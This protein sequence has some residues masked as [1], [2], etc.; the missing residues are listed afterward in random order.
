MFCIKVSRWGSPF[1][2]STAIHRRL[3]TDFPLQ[4]RVPASSSSMSSLD[5]CH[6]SV[7]YTA[8]AYRGP[9]E[10]VLD[11]ASRFPDA[12]FLVPQKVYRPSTQSDRPRSVDKFEPEPPIMFLTQHPDGCGINCRDAMNSRSSRLHGRDDS[13]FQNRGPS[14]SIRINVCALLFIPSEYRY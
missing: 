12:A 8:P 11:I 13:M 6:T 5:I 3:G 4:L 1:R 2:D 10:S 14:V 9:V 7:Q